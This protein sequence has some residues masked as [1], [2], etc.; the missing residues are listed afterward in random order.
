MPLDREKDRRIAQYAEVVGAV[1]VL[2]DVFA[3]DHQELSYG[4]LQTG[5]EFVA[6]AGVQWRRGARRAAQKR[7]QHV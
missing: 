5:M 2:P 7:V 3:V 1:R 4:L 6:K